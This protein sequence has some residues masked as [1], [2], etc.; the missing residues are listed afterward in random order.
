MNRNLDS[1]V[2]T[3]FDA[4]TVTAGGNSTS[5][6]I[7]VGKAGGSFSVQSVITGSGTLKIEYLCSNDGST[8]TAPSSN[9]IAAGLTVGTYFHSFTP[10]VCLYLKIKTTETGSS[11]PASITSNVLVQ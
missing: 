11:D 7:A 2:T 4:Q 9:E 3:V 5:D 10:P 8:F 1:D 6:A